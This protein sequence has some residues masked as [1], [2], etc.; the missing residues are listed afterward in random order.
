M[1]HKEHKAHKEQ[2]KRGNDNNGS[3]VIVSVTLKCCSL[4]SSCPGESRFRY[5]DFAVLRVSAVKTAVN[6]P[7]LTVTRRVCIL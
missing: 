3:A 7:A 1:H 6:Q 5:P 2:R 4:C